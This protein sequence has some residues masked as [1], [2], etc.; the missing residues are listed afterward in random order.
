[1]YVQRKSNQLLVL[2]CLLPYIL[3]N[4]QV[5]RVIWLLGRAK[6]TTTRIEA[7][8]VDVVN[9]QLWQLLLMVIS[10]QLVVYNAHMNRSICTS[11]V[12]FL[13]GIVLYC[14]CKH[15]KSCQFAEKRY[16][17]FLIFFSCSFLKYYSNEYSLM[18]KK[19]PFCCKML[20]YIPST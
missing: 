14:S 18:H 15:L 1:M 12:C 13:S 7:A 4:L 19:C 3:A 11:K 2:F 17:V 6:G 16:L 8:N 5:Q 20:Q 10:R 9:V